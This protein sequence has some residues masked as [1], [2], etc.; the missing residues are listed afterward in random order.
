MNRPMAIPALDPLYADIRRRDP[1]RPGLILDV[2]EL[3]EFR[4]ARVE[5]SLFVPMSQI[6]VRLAD[7][8]RDRPLMVMCATGSRSSS[9]TSFLLQQGY[10]DVGNLAGGIDGWQRM[11]LPVKHGPIEDGEGQLPG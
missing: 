2:R 8:P 1:A 5:G 11:G 9:V 10:E 7:I 3:D 6:Q 4:Q